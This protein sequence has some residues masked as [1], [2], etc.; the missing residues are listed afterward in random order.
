MESEF[1]P[2]IQRFLELVQIDGE[3]GNESATAL[4][5][6][7]HLEMAG[8]RVNFDNAGQ[9]SGSNSGNLIAIIDATTGDVPPLLLNSHLDTVVPGNNIKPIIRDGTITSD[10]TT[11][12]GADNRAG[13]AAIIDGLTTLAQSN[14]S[15]GRIEVLL[16][17]CE[18]SGLLG[19]KFCDYS[20]ISAHHGF[21]LDSSGLGSII[22]S[23]PGY[24][25]I[26]VTIRGRA[27]HAGIDP[28]SGINAIRLCAQALA[29]IPQGRIDEMTTINIGTITGGVA[30]N[31]VAETCRSNLEIRS[32]NVD[33]L[34]RTV[35]LVEKA[36]RDSIAK[37][38]FSVN[39]QTVIPE[40]TF[41]RDREFEA[42]HV[43]ETHDLVAISKHAISSIGR[44][45]TVMSKMGGSDA[46]VFNAKGIDTVILGTG[47]TAVHSLD[48][49]ITISDL[50][51]GGRL[52][53]QLIH[54]WNSYW[55]KY[56][57]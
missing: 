19:A 28:E 27:A 29:L 25:A 45:A 41:I 16:T 36:F 14:A 54:S 44:N 35:K 26:D 9:Q 11:I 18:E 47:Q 37:Q 7:K 48:E 57:T 17:I 53:M 50:I 30:R 15:H 56:I 52:V 10:G 2:I 40:L 24:E 8:A 5:C 33:T 34:E 55:R 49:R 43:P 39:H 23:A 46:N 1:P 4:Y 6:K 13:L 51:D 22:T 31:I 3:S 32:H 20:T 38:A 42:F 12:L 21:S